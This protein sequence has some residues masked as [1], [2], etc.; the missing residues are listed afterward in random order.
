MDDKFDENKFFN[1]EEVRYYEGLIEKQFKECIEEI[2]EKGVYD[3]DSD[4]ALVR[5]GR[6]I[7][8]QHQQK[9]QVDHEWHNLAEPTY[10]VNVNSKKCTGV[11]LIF[12][13]KFANQ[14]DK[15]RQGSSTDTRRLTKAWES[16]G[17][18][19][20]AW[21]DERTDEIL[22]TI[23]KYADKYAEHVSTFGVTFMSHGKENLHIDTFRGELDIMVA[24]DIVKNC[25]N[26]K[27]KPKLFFIQSCRGPSKMKKVARVAPA[28]FPRDADI[29]F[30]F[31]TTENHKSFR[32]RTKLNDKRVCS[33]FVYALCCEINEL[34]KDETIEIYKLLLRVN[35]AVAQFALDNE[36]VG[37]SPEIKST[38][39]K[40]L[41]LSKKNNLNM[42]R[43]FSLIWDDLT[44]KLNSGIDKQAAKLI[45]DHQ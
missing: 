24:V 2:N 18:L 13:Q 14:P 9:E 28:T 27:G 42:K 17:F 45:E 20:Y 23:K 6:N 38:M 39:L 26:L 8:K 15:A 10:E 36:D 19:V 3:H 30:H 25:P 41:H 31:S 7:V 34:S 12:N 40:E 1:D 21:T 43:K 29:L 11:M 35:R 4:D 5:P 44:S 33:W 16:L 37:Q 32:S 22:G